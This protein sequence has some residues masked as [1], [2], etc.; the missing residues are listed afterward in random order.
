MDPMTAFLFS[1][2]AAGLV[3]SVLGANRQQHWIDMGKKLENEQF[4][5]NLEAIKTQSADESLTE[6]KELGKNIGSM[7]VMDAAKGN[8]AGTS[9]WG[10]T[11]AMGAFENDERRRRMNLLA[12]EVNLRGGNVLANLN[13]LRSETQ[14]GQSLTK[15]MFDTIPTGSLLSGGK[16]TAA[17]TPNIETPKSKETSLFTWG[18]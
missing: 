14:L 17:S 8:R 11:E 10:T 3:T 4:L 2:Q 18:V 15:S 1:M 9:A 13:T 5:T 16:K 6:M 7:M 12:N